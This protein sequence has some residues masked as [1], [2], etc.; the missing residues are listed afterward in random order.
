MTYLERL[1]KLNMH[2]GG[3]TKP[4]KVLLS[5][6]A[7]PVWRVSGRVTLNVT[8]DLLSPTPTQ[9]PC[10]QTLPRLIAVSRSLQCAPKIFQ[11][12]DCDGGWL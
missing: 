3:L 2:Q 11:F 12:L 7:V 5:V 4:T 6:L 10:L 9:A 1:K 8:C